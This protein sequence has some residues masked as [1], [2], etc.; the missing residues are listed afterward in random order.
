MMASNRK[1][2][3]ERGLG[4]AEADLRWYF[5]QGASTAAGDM[6]LRSSLGSQLEAMHAGIFAN[7]VVNVDAIE[8]RMARGVDAVGRMRLV[9][10]ALG[11][12]SPIYQ[13]AIRLAFGGRDMRPG[14]SSVVRLTAEA[15]KATAAIVGRAPTDGEVE[16]AILVAASDSPWLSKAKMA[17]D[18]ITA[19]ALQAYADG[20]ALLGQAHRSRMQWEVRR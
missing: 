5:G 18:A 19:A 3:D 6:G 13:K 17:A 12:L 10:Q 16:Q 9:E 7:P 1:T 11:G 20:R 4:P 15:R 8:M 14:V 2:I